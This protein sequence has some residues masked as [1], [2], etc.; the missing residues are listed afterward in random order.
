MFEA[1]FNAPISDCAVVISVFNVPTSLSN[2]STVSDVVLYLD[3]SPAVIPELIAST[4]ACV[5]GVSFSVY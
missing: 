4:C 5:K 2:A 3:T 1:V